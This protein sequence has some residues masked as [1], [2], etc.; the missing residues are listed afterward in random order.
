[1]GYP[2]KW[3]SALQ[4]CR[5]ILAQPDATDKTYPVNVRPSPRIQVPVLSECDS[6]ACTVYPIVLLAGHDQQNT[7][8]SA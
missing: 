4:L 7:R 5:S 2:C 6:N 8:M 3:Y 1:M